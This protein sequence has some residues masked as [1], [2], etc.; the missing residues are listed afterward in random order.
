[1]TTARW[2]EEFDNL[3]DESMKGYYRPWE[4]DAFLNA[5]IQEWLSQAV[6]MFERD[7]EAV[8]FLVLL[9]REK[10]DTSGS[11]TIALPTRDMKAIELV[12]SRWS[13][14]EY[15]TA[16]LAKANWSTDSAF[17][18]PSNRFP[19]YRE[20]SDEAG[21]KIRLLSITPPLETRVTY[22]IE[23]PRVSEESL[24]REWDRV[25]SLSVQ[26]SII[27]RAIS[28]TAIPAGDLVRLRTEA[29]TAVNQ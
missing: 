5:V 2:Y 7:E 18:K 24:D 27:R 12:E 17:H 19:A 9:T 26:Y 23:P 22:I 15:R 25:F 20:L 1:M 8:N 3:L 13:G 11:D 4:K 29:P 16:G 6:K 21:A 10:I 28:L 14:G